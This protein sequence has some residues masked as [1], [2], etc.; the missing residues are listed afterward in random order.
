MRSQLALLLFLVAG[1]AS[2][3]ERTIEFRIKSEHLD[4]E[5]SIWISLPK[6]YAENKYQCHTLYLL[7]ADQI[8]S[9]QTIKSIRN[10][11]FENG[12]YIQPLIIVGITQINRS[13]ELSPYGKTGAKFLRYINEEVIP[14]IDS[15]FNT[16]PDRII[17]GHSLGGYFAL[18]TWMASI[19]FNSCFA[20]S[21]AIYYKENRITADLGDYL[22]RE[23]PKGI[24][25]INNG[26]ESITEL[27]IK[28]YISDLTKTF[29]SNASDSLFFKYKEY[30]GYGHNF[31]PIV[32]TTDGLL[33]HF[34]K[35][36]FDENTI[37]KLRSKELER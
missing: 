3:Q 25:Y 10:Q 2:A 6:Y 9:S 19:K 31:T 22:N 15:T 32:G 8:Q 27:R 18:H 30:E 36:N 21:P 13:R 23:H 4:Q 35:W 14:L 26:T 29:H 11:L 37:S 1:S 34:S 16:I 20:F 28:K 7:D 24:L 5:R 17:A 12:G 33:F